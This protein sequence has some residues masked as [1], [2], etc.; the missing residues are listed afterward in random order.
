MRDECAVVLA[1]VKQCSMLSE[2]LKHSD[3]KAPTSV[4]PKCVVTCSD[5]GT[6]VVVAGQN[7]VSE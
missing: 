7:S 3:T 2:L 5:T 4:Q 1:V 6:E